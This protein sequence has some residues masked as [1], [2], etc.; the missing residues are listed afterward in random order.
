MFKQT[1]A[2]VSPSHIMMIVACVV[3]NSAPALAQSVD[4]YAASSRSSSS[5]VTYAVSQ[6]TQR[7]EMIVNSSRIL[8]L[9]KVVP[10]FQVQNE[11]ILI[12]NPV[13]PN[14]VQISAQAAGVTQLNLWD[15]DDT[16]YTVDVIVTGDARELSTV[17]QAQFPYAS[18]RITPLP[19]GAVID[20]TVTDT[21]DIDRV[22]AVAEQFY[23]KVVNNI[24][25]VGV[26]TILLHTKVMEVSRTKLRDLGLD[27]GTAN[28]TSV[29]AFGINGTVDALKSSIGSVVATG[30][31]NARVGLLR[32]GESLDFLIRALQQNNCAKILAEPTVVATHGRP[33]RFIVGGKFPIIAPDGQGGSTVTFEEFGTSVDF[34]PFLVG[35]GRVRLEIRPEVSERDDAN[36]VALNGFTVPAIRQRYVETAVEMQ[37]GQTY[38]IAGLLQTRTETISTGPPF[39][40]SVPWIGTLFRHVESVENEIELLVTVTPELVDAM[41][42]HEVMPGGPGVDTT[43]PSD[44]ELYFKG[45]IEVPRVDSINEK[46]CMQEPVYEPLAPAMQ[47][48]LPVQ[49]SS[50]YTAPVSQP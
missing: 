24:K 33:S 35:P 4:A 1:M 12:A 7:L 43:V 26:Q 18:L 48:T 20:G 50:T 16:L 5:A 28:S 39:L 34:L 49:E 40:I 15:V 8:K 44:T 37:A 29:F 42:P 10:R 47:Q 46:G 21:D 14:Q 30:A 22:M 9:E 31:P 2:G 11:E 32:N 13:A 27:W 17:M 23:P 19:T 6:P 25:V 36:G 41:D 45:Y 3:G 38:A